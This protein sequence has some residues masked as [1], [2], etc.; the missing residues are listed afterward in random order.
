MS[1]LR[2]ILSG[3]NLLQNKL[4]PSLKSICL[5]MFITL[6]CIML[7]LKNGKTVNVLSKALKKNKPEQQQTPNQ[8]QPLPG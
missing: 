2:I 8:T 6:L 1:G 3:E 5:V 4:W 7:N